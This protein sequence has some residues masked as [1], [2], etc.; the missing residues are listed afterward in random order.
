MLNSYNKI[1]TKYFYFIRSQDS[2]NS[3]NE[4]EVALS[5]QKQRPNKN[6]DSESKIPSKFVKFKETIYVTAKISKLN[7]EGCSDRDS[8]KQIVFELKPSYLILVRGL[9]ANIDAVL[10][11]SKELLGDNIF[12]PK[13]RNY[14]NFVNNSY[15]VKTFYFNYFNLI[16]I[17]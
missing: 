11:Y 8:L 16:R 9:L 1:N 4:Q 13:L 10:E 12:S 5:N 7:F 14:L 17:K 15:E 6:L 3:E 2:F